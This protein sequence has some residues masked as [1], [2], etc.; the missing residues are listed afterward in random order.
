MS[1]LKSVKDQTPFGN[2]DVWECT[3]LS[4]LNSQCKPPGDWRLHWCIPSL[5]VLDSGFKYLHSSNELYRAQMLFTGLLLKLGRFSW[6]GS[7][8]SWVDCFWKVAQ[9]VKTQ[10]YAFLLLHS[11]IYLASTKHC[12]IQ[13]IY[14]VY[15]KMHNGQ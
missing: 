1:K 11:P 9:E 7:K 13:K 8:R 4:F 15:F 2:S 6:I 12:W 10:F 5:I 3:R 14:R